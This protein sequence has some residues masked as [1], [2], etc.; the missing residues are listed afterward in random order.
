[1]TRATTVNVP[2]EKASNLNHV[3]NPTVR[4]LLDNRLNPDQGLHLKQKN[5][6]DFKCTN[7]KR[8]TLNNT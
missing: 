1:M 3:L 2:T 6:I 5:H 7:V 4:V 8:T